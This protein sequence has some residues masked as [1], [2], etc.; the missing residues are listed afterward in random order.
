MLLSIYDSFVY[1]LRKIAAGY[2]MILKN[3][4]S[5]KKFKGQLGK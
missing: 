5:F 3:N 4:H 2:K 1:D